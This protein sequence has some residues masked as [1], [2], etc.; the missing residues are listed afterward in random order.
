VTL[1]SREAKVNKEEFLDVDREDWWL[2]DPAAD[3]DLQLLRDQLGAALGYGAEQDWYTKP[4]RLVPLWNMIEART[5][6]ATQLERA[7]DAELQKSWVETMTQSKE[8]ENKIAKGPDPGEAA[9][10]PTAAVAGAV[11]PAAAAAPAAPA[12]KKA[13]PFKKKDDAPSTT[14]PDEAASAPAAARSP[15]APKPAA[16]AEA[17]APTAAPDGPAEVEHVDVEELKSSVSLLE[18]AGIDLSA[19]DIDKL[20]A[21]PA[22]DER[23]AEATAELRAQAAAEGDDEDWDDDEEEE[24]LEPAGET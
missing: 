16:D 24:E 20:A 5:D 15:F 1:G 10:Q 11:A 22:F 23:L 7:T 6:L 21:A 3:R 12:V 9:A 18:T 8:A 4:D 17:A 14:T 19:E 2:V 13:S